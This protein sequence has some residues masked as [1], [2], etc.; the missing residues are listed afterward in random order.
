MQKVQNKKRSFLLTF[1][2]RCDDV[3]TQRRLQDNVNQTSSRR[4]KPDVLFPDVVT[5]PFLV[6][7]CRDLFKTSLENV[8]KRSVSAGKLM[9]QFLFISWNYKSNFPPIFSYFP[10]HLIRLQTTKVNFAKSVNLWVFNSKCKHN[11]LLQQI[12]I[13]EVFWFLIWITPAFSAI[14]IW[15]CNPFTSCSSLNS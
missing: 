14:T 11:F 8:L 2:R 6:V 9:S 4:R 12:N 1:Y 15:L 3:A 7:R 13:F 10:L 5:T